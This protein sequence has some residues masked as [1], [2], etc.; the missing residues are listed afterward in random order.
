MT[1]QL[2]VDALLEQMGVTGRR[3]DHLHAAEAGAGNI[4]ISV[5]WDI[6][7]ES[8]F[9]EKQA[10]VKLPWKVP[11]LAGRTVFV[12]GSG[13]RLREVADAPEKNVSAFI[14]DEG[15]KTGTWYTHPNKAYQRPTSEFNSHLAVHN[16][17]V[18]QRGV[19]FQAIVHAQ[20]PYLV[21][22]SHIP[23]TLNNKDFNRMI[24]RWEPETIVQVPEGIAVL[25]FMVPGSDELM[26]N[27]VIGLRDHRIALWAK[28]GIMVRSDSSAL[29]AVDTIE[30]LETGAMYEHMNAASGGKGTGLSD[31]EIRRVVSAFNVKTDMY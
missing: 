17:Q 15:G 4:S 26:E 12:T 10:G 5:D 28:H 18:A 21:A 2:T 29:S 3:L 14:V 22:L 20:P 13:C 23:E 1:S 24:F 16:D 6:D 19:S 25:E 9:P 7:L 8:V 31:D 27:N 30:Y 11:A